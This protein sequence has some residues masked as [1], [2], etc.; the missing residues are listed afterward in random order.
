M[1]A[2]GLTKEWG[3]KG[4]REHRVRSAGHPDLRHHRPRQST[5]NVANVQTCRGSRTPTRCW[6]I[7]SDKA[8]TSTVYISGNP[9]R[10][11]S[12]TE[13]PG[14]VKAAPAQDPNSALFRIEGHQ[15][16]PPSAHPEQA[17]H[18]QLAQRSSAIAG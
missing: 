6:S 5:K 3:R 9:V 12:P 4:H 2:V 11:E 13:M 14:C 17:A 10:R 15:G 18:R 1:R 8:A 7:P 16:V